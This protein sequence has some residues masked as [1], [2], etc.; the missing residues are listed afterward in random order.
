MYLLILR[1]PRSI[2]ENEQRLV[3]SGQDNVAK[4][5]DMLTRGLLLQWASTTKSKPSVL[6]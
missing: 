3:G 4:W 1:Y 5:G 2:K 6:V